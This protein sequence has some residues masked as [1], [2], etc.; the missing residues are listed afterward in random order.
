[1]PTDE[2][3]PR[4]SDQCVPEDLKKRPAKETYKRDL[5][6]RP[7]KE[8]YKRDVQTNST[9]QQTRLL[10]KSVTRDLQYSP[11]YASN[12]ICKRDLQKRPIKQTDKA[13]QYMHQCQSS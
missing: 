12:T 7:A 10:L 9:C 13:D 8:T 11:I 3:A 2:T 1:M 5:E 4:N 6:K